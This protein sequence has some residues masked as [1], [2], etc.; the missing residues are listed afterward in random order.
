M[1]RH[2]D[3]SPQNCLYGSDGRLAGVVDWEDAWSHA[4]PGFDVWN[5]ALAYLERG[6]AASGWSQERVVD[7]FRGVWGESRYWR[8]AGAAGREAARAA[9]AGEGQLDALEVAFFGHRLIERLQEPDMFPTT[10]WTA[11][12]MLEIV[13]EDR[14]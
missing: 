5:A 1:L 3:T 9:G 11:A 14:S 13:C 10:P 8:A 12:R 6:V 4:A 7:A 2:G